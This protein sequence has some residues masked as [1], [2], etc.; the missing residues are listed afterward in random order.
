MSIKRII[1]DADPAISIPQCDIDDGLA[2]FMALNS[3]EVN[4][5]GITTVF[6]NSALEDVTKVAKD[7]LKVANRQDI[8]VFKGAYNKNWLGVKTEATEFLINH[9]SENPNEI[10]LVTLGPLTNVGSIFKQKPEIIDDLK[11]LVIMGGLT[12]PDKFRFSFIKTEFNIA[13]D[14][15]AANI[16]FS[17]P[18]ETTLI[19]LEVTTKVLFKDAHY[20][21]VKN[22]KTK[23]TEYLTTHIKPWLAHSKVLMK[24]FN[25]H[26]PIAL[27]Y[28][29]KESLFKSINLGLKVNYKKRDFS[30]IDT[31]YRKGRGITAMFST[32]EGK[33]T[34]I[35]DTEIS[36]KMKI[37]V[38]TEIDEKEFMKL[39][40]ERLIKYKK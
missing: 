17:Q 18:I 36:E 35:P 16:V 34:I 11:E 29:L 23:W 8:Q 31:K 39:F 14:G 20:L 38:C 21:A 1:I 15:L 27:A 13:N 30:K 6:G 2:L 28:V 7:I 4:V 12:F 40:L 32:K 5:E 9:I 3:P 10:T 26:D 37:R 22:S 25:P 24:G 19:G 33:I